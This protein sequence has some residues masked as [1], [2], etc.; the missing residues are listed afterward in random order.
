M[1]PKRERPQRVSRIKTGTLFVIPAS[2][3]SAWPQIEAKVPPPMRGNLLVIQDAAQA[4]DLVREFL[5]QNPDKT[6][7][8]C[9]IGDDLGTPLRFS[10]NIED[11]LR[12]TSW[13]GNRL[14]KF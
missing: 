14:S 12:L 11:S 2:M 9:L 5:N 6:T 3:E 13:P 8:I 10:D 1:P 7:M 4:G